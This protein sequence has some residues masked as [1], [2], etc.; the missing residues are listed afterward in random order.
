MAAGLF[1]VCRLLHIPFFVNF[2][3]LG[4]ET[5]LTE[6]AMSPCATLESHM[7][8][9][10]HESEKRHIIFEDFRRFDA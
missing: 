8:A 2:K 5:C 10:S 1:D 6:D 9:I 4:G 7:P 3:I